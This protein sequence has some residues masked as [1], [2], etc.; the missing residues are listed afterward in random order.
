MWPLSGYESDCLIYMYRL[1]F[2]NCLQTCCKATQYY[3]CSVPCTV[4]GHMPQ[5]GVPTFP[6][7]GPTSSSSGPMSVPVR[8]SANFQSSSAR[9]YKSMPNQSQLYTSTSYIPPTTPP[10]GEEG[11]H[12]LYVHVCVLCICMLHSFLNYF[13]KLLGATQIA[14]HHHHC[15]VICEHTYI[16]THTHTYTHTHTHTHTR[17]HTPLYWY[18]NIH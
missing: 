7:S 6:L 15:K 1:F 9:E 3:T 2:C 16:H 5:Q 14:D 11:T 18:N 17:T 4:H 13:I 8:P 10:F 12:T